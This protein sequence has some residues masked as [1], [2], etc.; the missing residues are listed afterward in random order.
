VGEA[1]NCLRI[2][3]SFL[4]AKNAPTSVKREII[5]IIKKK[6]FWRPKY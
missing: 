4:R 6:K 5:I 2:N 1:K 3:M